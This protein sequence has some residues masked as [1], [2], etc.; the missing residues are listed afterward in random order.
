M[1]ATVVMVSLDVA[2]AVDAVD[3]VDVENLTAIIKH[4]GIKAKG[5]DNI[6]SFRVK[7]ANAN[8]IFLVL[9]GACRTRGL[10]NT[11]RDV[12]D[13]FDFKLP[14]GF[15]DRSQLW[16]L[17]LRFQVIDTTLEKSTHSILER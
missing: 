1:S 3:V 9:G 16:I 17:Y 15:C 10:Q 4:N 8:N 14:L 2:G 5:N 12:R 6:E 11:V 13:L 7:L